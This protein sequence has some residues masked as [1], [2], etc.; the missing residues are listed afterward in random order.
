MK[1]RFLDIN[2]E[3]IKAGLAAYWNWKE[4]GELDAI[5]DLVCEIHLAMNQACTEKTV[6]R[7]EQPHQ[8]SHELRFVSPQHR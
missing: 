3:Q 6:G 1:Y 4:Q 8:L 2:G 7:A 5:A